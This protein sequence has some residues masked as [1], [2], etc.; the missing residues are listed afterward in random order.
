MEINV[1]LEPTAINDAIAKAVVESR[2]GVALKERIESF[3]S[4]NRGYGS[5]SFQDAMKYAVDQE[6][7][8]IVMALIH[9]EYAET[10]R[11]TVR[12][13]MTEAVISDLVVKAMGKLS[14]RY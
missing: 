7:M 11:E 4:D 3:L 1:N 13:H 10:I 12:A 6:L 14:S 2:L 8:K 9:N 5:P